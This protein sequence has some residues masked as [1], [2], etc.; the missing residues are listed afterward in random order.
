M[1]LQI[2]R[3]GG[4][5]ANAAPSVVYETSQVV[6]RKKYWLL[7]GGF[8][9][10]NDQINETALATSGAGP[11]QIIVVHKGPGHGALGHY[12]ALDDPHWIVR[13]VSQMVSAL[14]GSPVANVVFAAGEIGVDEEQKKYRDEILYWVRALCPGAQVSWPRPGADSHYG[15]AY[16]L[17]LDEEVALFKN[18]PKGGA[19]DGTADRDPNSGIRIHNYWATPLPPAPPPAPRPRRHSFTAPDMRPPKPP[20]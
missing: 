17:P 2:Y 16:Y 15:A 11:C 12:A 10:A 7:M 20:H 1:P 4:T 18:Q 5:F 8:A 3:E 14:G 13:G 19:W 9:A 6:A